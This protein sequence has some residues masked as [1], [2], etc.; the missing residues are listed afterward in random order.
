MRQ[1]SFVALLDQ[2]S[3]HCGRTLAAD[4]NGT[5]LTGELV[6]RWSRNA[7]WLTPP[8]LSPEWIDALPYSWPELLGF[9]LAGRLLDGAARENVI[10][11]F[12]RAVAS[13]EPA[14][15][16][17][18][19]WLPDV[20]AL[21]YLHYRIEDHRVA[22]DAMHLMLQALETIPGHLPSN[23]FGQYKLYHDIYDLA[24]TCLVAELR[25]VAQIDA[26]FVAGR[27]LLPAT[28]ETLFAV[29][30]RLDDDKDNRQPNDQRRSEL[31]TWSKLLSRRNK[32]VDGLFDTICR[33]NQSFILHGRFPSD[34]IIS[35]AREL[36]LAWF[37]L[38]H[39]CSNV[40]LGNKVAR[41][42]R[43]LRSGNDA[44][45]AIN[46]S[47]LQPRTTSAELPARVENGKLHADKSGK[48]I[49]NPSEEEANLIRQFDNAL[50]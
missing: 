4:A 29:M 38:A 3:T 8:S 34:A 44:I 20:L 12:Q 32:V 41:A 37:R 50:P 6:E 48:M 42:L 47:M 46:R 14:L 40:N 39:A 31:T 36:D 33:L 18:T 9:A 10:A 35:H 26:A 11:A 15:V 30:K 17:G 13:F 5:A 45:L 25:D 27:R 16:K 1:N 7:E 49:F 19:V 23:D 24:E 43:Q 21:R 2:W 28:S 22:L